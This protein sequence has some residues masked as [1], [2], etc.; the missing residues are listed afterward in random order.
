MKKGRVDSL[1]AL[2][3]YSSSRSCFLLIVNPT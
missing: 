1:P 3:K 2:L